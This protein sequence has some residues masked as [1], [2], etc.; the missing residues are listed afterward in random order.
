MHHQQQESF[1]R[2]EAQASVQILAEMIRA[3]VGKL[4]LT[5]SDLAR[6][7]QKTEGALRLAES[8]FRSRQGGAELL[9]PPLLKN[10]EGRIWSVL[11]VAAWMA[12]CGGA[13]GPA[14][15]M[16]EPPSAPVRRRGRPR[17]TSSSSSSAS[18]SLT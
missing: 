12:G 5:T 3:E 18:G 9:P 14:D 8:R 6:L 17:K 11:Q 1:K 4:V 7:L 16:H 2:P 10:G 13:H 15:A